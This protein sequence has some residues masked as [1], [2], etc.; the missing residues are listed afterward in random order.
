MT[1]S[2]TYRM[3][4]WQLTEFAK[5]FEYRAVDIPHPTGGEVLVRTTACGVCHSD[6]HVWQGYFDLGEGRRLSFA[7]GMNL[8]VAL[9][10]EIAGEVVAM[11]P[12]ARGVAI[13]DR[14]FVFPW[15]GCGACEECAADNEHFCVGAR[16]GI[17]IRTSGGFGEYVLVP[18]ARYLVD[19]VGIP[20]AV[21]CTYACSGLTAYSALKKLP[22]LT[23]DDSVLVI[24]AGGVGLSAVAI[25]PQV[26][27]ARIVVADIDPM[28][29][30]AALE[31][32]AD[33]AVDNGAEDAVKQVRTIAPRGVHAVIDF[34]GRPETA[35]FGL[36]CLRRAGTLIL[37]GL[38][39]GALSLP[40]AT[41][42]PRLLTIRG[43]QVGSLTE[44]RELVELAKTGRLAPIPIATRPMSRSF[45]TIADLQAGRV[46]GRIVLEPDFA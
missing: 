37:V 28:K 30:A 31:A 44:L 1:E 16:R 27:P 22:A 33:L 29:R 45:E 10:H 18:N 23:A 40:L 14:R 12:D 4:C 36:D 34:V 39:G 41:V 7:A 43:S 26:T 42:P 21:A 2:T 15:L 38:Y 3:R 46:T 24:G 35:Q 6:V 20:E 9:G 8:P 17:G 5:P 25:A 13:G 19:F 11:G 32:G